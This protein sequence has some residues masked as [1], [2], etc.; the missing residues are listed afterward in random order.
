MNLEIENNNLK[1]HKVN[2][3]E[4]ISGFE[5]ISVAHFL[6]KTSQ[7][8]RSFFSLYNL[9]PLDAK[10]TKFPKLS[11]DRSETSETILTNRNQIYFQKI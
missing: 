3:K 9:H 8:G 4:R 10:R 2:W 5:K 11:M 1:P 6:H 7:L